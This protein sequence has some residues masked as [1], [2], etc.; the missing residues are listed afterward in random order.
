MPRILATEKPIKQSLLIDLLKKNGSDDEL[1]SMSPRF[2]VELDDQDQLSDMSYAGNGSLGSGKKVTGEAIVEEG[3]AR[4]TFKANEESEFFGKTIIGEIS[5]DVPV[6]TRD[7]QPVKQLADAKK[8]E[9]T[10]KVVVDNKTTQLGHFVAYEVRWNSEVRTTI[11]FSEKPINVAKLKESLAKNGTD[12]GLIDFSSQ[13]KVTIDKEDRPAFLN[14]YADGVSLSQNTNL[15]GDMIVEDNRARGTVKF[16]KPVDFFKK[17]INF[18]LTF[19][20]EVLP[21]PATAKE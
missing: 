17:T 3:R 14:L 16:D 21:L 1:R 5:F 7:S 13:V 12:D 6:L 20:L 9:T 2:M 15:V 11:L 4:G 18:D 8:L 10:G 19:D